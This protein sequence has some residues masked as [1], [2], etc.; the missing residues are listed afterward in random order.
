MKPLSLY[1]HLPFCLSRC[2]YCSFCSQTDLGLT[3]PYVRALVREIRAVGRR[4][5]KHRVITVYFGGGTP[6]LV[7]A[8]R[9]ALLLAEV[10]NAFCCDGQMEISLECNPA[11]V[12]EDNAFA[13]VQAGVNRF[14]V[15]LQSAEDAT[16]KLLGRAHTSAD[17]TDTVRA[18][19]RAGAVNISADLIIGLPSETG[20][21]LVKSADFALKTG[22]THLSAYGLSVEE[23]TK[24]YQSG[25]RVDEDLCADGYRMLVEYLKAQGFMRYEISN[26]SLPGKECRHN[27]SYWNLTDY[28]GFGAS[29]HSLLSR[30]RFFHSD[31]VSGYIASPFALVS[32][33][34]LSA[35]EEEQELL[36]LGLRTESGVS[37]SELKSRFGCDFMQKYGERA[38]ALAPY[39]ILDGDRVRFSDEGF[40]LSNALLARLL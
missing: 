24:L 20:E 15:G 27:Q 37:V 7:G 32:E 18:L 10:K 16:L 38:R 3:E 23:G 2:S 35:E 19:R 17:F 28:Y 31:D 33:E 4:L 30:R 9:I 21:T 12:G 6:S 29:A 26:F 25:Y 13:F 8:E 36:M 34:K 14:S 22:V 40:Y 11:T 1:F 5:K 39:L